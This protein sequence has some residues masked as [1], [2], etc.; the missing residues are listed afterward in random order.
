MGD[1]EYF[2][3]ANEVKGPQPPIVI[4]ICCII[5]IIGIVIVITLNGG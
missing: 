1:Y 4:L 2:N 3:C 5:Y